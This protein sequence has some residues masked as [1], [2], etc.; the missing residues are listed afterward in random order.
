M[1]N[2]DWPFATTAPSLKLR[3]CRMPVTRARTSTSREPTVCPTY[4][5]VTGSEAGVTVTTLTS[6]A[7]W[8]PGPPLPPLSA[9]EGPQAASTSGSRHSSRERRIQDAPEIVEGLLG[10]LPSSNMDGTD[11]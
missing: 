3:D 8:A 7:G 2:M 5:K 4:S 10:M 9:L 1:V 6:A 11:G